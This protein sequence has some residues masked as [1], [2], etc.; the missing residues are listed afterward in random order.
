MRNIFVDFEMNPV[1]IEYA[2][3][4]QISNYEIIEIGAVMLDGYNHRIDDFKQ[5]IKP[6][7]NEAIEERIT[8]LTGTR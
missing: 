3:E 5:Y 7:Y 1:D 8:G 4:R 2:E 6:V